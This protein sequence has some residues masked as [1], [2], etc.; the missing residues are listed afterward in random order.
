MPNLLNA[1]RVLFS[2]TLPLVLGSS[3]CDRVSEEAPAPIVDQSSL[4]IGPLHA[5]I[6]TRHGDIRIRLRP[7]AAPITCANFVNLVDRGFYDGLRFYQ[8]SR[9]IRQVGNPYHDRDRRW[10]P[11]YTINPEFSAD[12]RFDVGGRVAMV[13]ETDDPAAPVRPSEFFITTKPQTE[14]FTFTYPIFGEVVSGQDAVN[15]LVIDDVIE[16]IEIEGDTGPL[17]ARHEALVAA[18]SKALDDSEF[19]ARKRP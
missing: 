4:P 19:G 18:W 7:D 2:I 8:Q 3:G 13:R 15:R 5:T 12:L 6:A 11:G 9:V 17:L 1:A 10:S 14:R 16:R